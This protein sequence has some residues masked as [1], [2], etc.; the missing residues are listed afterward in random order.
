MFVKRIA[1]AETFFFFPTFIDLPATVGQL[2]TLKLTEDQS[3]AST[4]YLVVNRQSYQV[5]STERNQAAALERYVVALG[6]KEIPH[7]LTT[8]GTNR[9]AWEVSK[10]TS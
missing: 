10:S 6:K 7:L 4:G 3:Y 5:S 1:R 9:S 2:F 8:S